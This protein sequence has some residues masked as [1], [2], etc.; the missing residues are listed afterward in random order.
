MSPTTPTYRLASSNSRSAP[1]TIDF[2]HAYTLTKSLLRHPSCLH[3]RN[4]STWPC[5]ACET[6]FT[7]KY[8]TCAAYLLDYFADFYA[9]DSALIQAVWFYLLDVWQESANWL[10]FDAV[11]ED[12]DARRSAIAAMAAEEEDEEENIEPEMGTSMETDMDTGTYLRLS[13]GSGSAANGV[14]LVWGAEKARFFE[15]DVRDTIGLFETVIWGR[16]ATPEMRDQVLYDPRGEAWCPAGEYDTGPWISGVKPWC[17]FL[18][19]GGPGVA[20]PVFASLAPGESY[21]ASKA[22]EKT[23]TTQRYIPHPAIA[24]LKSHTARARTLAHSLFTSLDPENLASSLADFDSHCVSF[25]TP[26]KPSHT[27][28]SVVTS[29]HTSYTLSNGAPPILRSPGYGDPGMGVRNPDWNLVDECLAVCKGVPA[30]E[31]VNGAGGQDDDDEEDESDDEV[32]DVFD[33]WTVVEKRRG[34]AGSEGVKK[35]D[36][37]EM[38]DTWCGV[39]EC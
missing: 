22:D 13:A 12:V 8:W 5:L 10:P 9:E 1:H 39:D 26:G 11:L 3:R 19:E 29:Q 7:S 18:G 15:R 20:E 2:Q 21:E 28:V 6:S 35:L 17:Q 16:R 25:P 37:G 36:L 24:L 33:L 31:G 23:K 38:F 30:Y 4:A 14:E 34:D 27:Y 32:E